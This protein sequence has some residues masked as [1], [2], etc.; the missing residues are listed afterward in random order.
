MYQTVSNHV[1]NF[2]AVFPVA[3]VADLEV[4]WHVTET[5]FT[6]FLDQLP[7]HHLDEYVCVCVFVRQ[8]FCYYV[9]TLRLFTGDLPT[10]NKLKNNALI[11]TKIF[12]Q[13]RFSLVVNNANS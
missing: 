8:L 3:V 6:C 4:I 13:Y 10:E 11:N 7:G 1:Q 12:F 5:G 2:H 9:Q